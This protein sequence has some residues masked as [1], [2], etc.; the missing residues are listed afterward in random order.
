MRSEAQKVVENLNSDSHIYPGDSLWPHG[1]QGGLEVTYS[2]RLHSGISRTTVKL[3]KRGL[4][5]YLVPCK[6]EEEEEQAT[7]CPSTHTMEKSMS[8]A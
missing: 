1:R 3:R 4:Y 7:L 5:T 6:R 8:T 2:M